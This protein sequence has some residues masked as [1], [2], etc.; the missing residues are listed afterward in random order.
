MATTLGGKLQI[1][2]R[3]KHW[4]LDKDSFLCEA[5]R[6]RST[7]PL[8]YSQDR[9]GNNPYVVSVIHRIRG[10]VLTGNLHAFEI[11]N[12]AL[13]HESSIKRE[14]WDTWCCEECCEIHSE[15]WVPARFRVAK[16]A[17]WTDEL[18]EAKRCR[19]TLPLQYYLDR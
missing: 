15:I 4:K 14:P 5:R 7:L 9:T 16:W 6:C 1:T 13:I 10:D 3:L 18:Y 12:A 17:V 11:V 19:S 8:Q 2:H